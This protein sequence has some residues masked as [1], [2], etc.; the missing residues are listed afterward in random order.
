MNEDSTRLW[1]VKTRSLLMQ[2]EW[3]SVVSQDITRP[4]GSTADYQTI[5]F[6]RPAVGVVA[7]SGDEFLLIRQYRFI[8]D[9]MV[10]AIPSGGVDVGETAIEAAGRELLEETGYRA[11]HLE[12]ILWY[13][14]SYGCSDQRF[15]LYEA[16][17]PVKTADS[18]DVSEVLAVRWFG[19]DA[20]LKM[21]YSNEIVDGLSLTPLLF[22]LL[23]EMLAD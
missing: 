13:Y 1:K 16:R 5:R 4:D 17:D 18:F 15:D 2:N 20:I 12:P 6:A 19:K 23:G 21:I 14:P 8:V 10:W 9:R 7:R 3:F 22:L 11:V